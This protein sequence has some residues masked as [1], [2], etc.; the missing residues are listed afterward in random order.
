[1]N[2]NN[3][4]GVALWDAA[5]GCSDNHREA[6]ACKEARLIANARRNPWVDWLVVVGEDNYVFPENIIQA[7]FLFCD[8]DALAYGRFVR[9]KKISDFER[10]DIVL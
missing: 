7:C 4:E 5:G 1:M 3:A 2:N 10:P 8:S 9:R 6:V